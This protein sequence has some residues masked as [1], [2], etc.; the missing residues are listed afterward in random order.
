MLQSDRYLIVRCLGCAARYRVAPRQGVARAGQFP[1]PRCQEMIEV[2]EATG[3]KSVSHGEVFGVESP[4]P[5]ASARAQARRLAAADA[6]PVASRGSSF[7]FKF[8]HEQDERAVAATLPDVRGLED[9]GAA[10]RYEDAAIEPAWANGETPEVAAVEGH[11]GLDDVASRADEPALAEESSAGAESVVDEGASRPQVTPSKWRRARRFAPKG[12]AR[13]ARHSEPDEHLKAPMQLEERLSAV[14]VESVDEATRSEPSGLVSEERDDDDDIW[15]LARAMLSSR[16]R[17]L[18]Y[19]IASPVRDERSGLIALKSG[20]SKFP[21]LESQA[22][23]IDVDFES[24]AV[25]WQEETQVRGVGLR[26]WPDEVRQAYAPAMDDGDKTRPFSHPPRELDAE[27]AITAPIGDVPLA[28]DDEVIALRE[29]ELVAVAS[30]EPSLVELSEADDRD[31][32]LDGRGLPTSPVSV[33]RL[34]ELLA[35]QDSLEPGL[36]LE[37]GLEDE[38]SAEMLDVVEPAGAPPSQEIQAAQPAPLAHHRGWEQLANA[39]ESAHEVPRL[40]PPSTKPAA[41]IERPQ[42]RLAL[43]VGIVVALVLSFVL[44]HVIS[45]KRGQGQP[46]EGRGGVEAVGGASTRSQAERYQDAL[47]F[48]KTTIHLAALRDS[49]S[50]SARH[51]LAAEL[52]EDGR[53]AKALELVEGLWTSGQREPAVGLLYAKLLIK[54]ERYAAAR[55]VALDVLARVG[56]HAE[57]AA[58]FNQAIREDRGLRPPVVTLTQESGHADT[59]YALGGGKSVSLRFSRDGRAVYAFKPAQVTWREGWQAEV[60]SYTLC[61]VL[62]CRFQ[63]PSN[64]IAKIS[65]QDF[66]ALF[67]RV[68][69]ERQARYREERF[70]EL[71]WVREQGPDGQVRPYLY[72]TL[73]AWVPGFVNWPLEY[74]EHWKPWLSVE[75]SMAALERERLKDAIESLRNLQGGRFYRDILRERESADVVEIAGQLSELLTF[76]FVTTNWDRF[77]AVEAY[78]GVNNQFAQG[79]FVSIDNGAAFHTQPMQRV[80][81]LLPSLQRFSRRQIAA[82]R[83]IEPQSLDV[84]LFPLQ[85]EE[86]SQRLKVFWQQRDALLAH[87][88][89]LVKAHGEALVLAF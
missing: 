52:F 9:E 22:K 59:I 50:P 68:N 5:P 23:V 31:A 88:D 40:E 29:D 21:I 10:L 44:G 54:S 89:A 32:R 35:H 15:R 66:D 85:T 24:T 62:Q 67:D 74:T 46:G 56:Q 3:F 78:Y 55:T 39:V 87:V 7:V 79:R 75:T 8:D 19:E 16:S 69:T 82:L 30:Q 43:A 51:Q 25:P 18:S 27:G 28:E 45:T 63:I 26:A 41:V 83:A 20:Q 58:V 71:V 42:R 70:G 76:D 86:S 64:R 6:A 17:A 48:A 11:E 37:D 38:G 1:C 60:A 14:P 33:A 47:K 80:N 81:E 12:F 4:A 65:V 36:E 13:L 2:V 34:E 53:D 61:E 72:G 57:L 49:S 84:L 73:K 77:S